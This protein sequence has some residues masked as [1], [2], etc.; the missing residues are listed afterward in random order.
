MAIFSMAKS[1]ISELKKC[2]SRLNIGDNRLS[3]KEYELILTAFFAI[4]NLSKESI[5]DKKT[6]KQK[7]AEFKKDAKKSRGQ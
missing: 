7:V 2:V 4:D 6:Y 1:E 5:L 3:K